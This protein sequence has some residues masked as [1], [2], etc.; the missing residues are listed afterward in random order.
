MKGELKEHGFVVWLTGLPASGKTTIARGLENILRAKGV[1]LETFDGDEV[2]RNLSKGLGFSREDRDTHNK[3]I[4]YV[5]KLLTRNGVNAIVSLI[6]PYRSTRA[7]AREQLPKFVEVYLKCSVDECV[8][9]D[10]KGLY[11]KALAGEIIN[12]TGIQDPYEEPINP[13]VT[14]NTENNTSKQNI[15]KVVQKLQDL[16]Y[17]R[18]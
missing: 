16:G 17:L 4:I 11:K 14:I 3:R 15:N 5:C 9:R 10:P 8:K 2:R 1:K 12:M 7:Y 13:E 18:Q 6:S